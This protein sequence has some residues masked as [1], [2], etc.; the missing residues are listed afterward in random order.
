MRVQMFE[1]WK[2]AKQFLCAIPIE[3]KNDRVVIGMD[4]AGDAIRTTH[5]SHR[6]FFSMKAQPITGV[7]MSACVKGVTKMSAGTSPRRA[8]R[9]PDAWPLK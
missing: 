4:F 6:L 1:V 7:S 2:I 8:P 3:F 9:L 5:D